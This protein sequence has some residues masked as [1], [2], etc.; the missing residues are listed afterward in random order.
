MIYSIS[1]QYLRL[2]WAKHALYQQS[3]IRFLH[4]PTDAHFNTCSRNENNRPMGRRGLSLTSFC[5]LEFEI[6]SLRLEQSPLQPAVNINLNLA[7][8]I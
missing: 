2:S 8:D 3:C 1:I 6:L 7:F 5:E 4:Y